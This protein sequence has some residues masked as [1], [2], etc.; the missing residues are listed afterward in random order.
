[1][2]RLLIK[3]KFQHGAILSQLEQNTRAFEICKSTI[4]MLKQYIDYLIKYLQANSV[5]DLQEKRSG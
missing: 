4:P 5:I 2:T 1:M 3:L